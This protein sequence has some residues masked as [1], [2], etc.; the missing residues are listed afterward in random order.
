MIAYLSGKIYDIQ[1]S[2]VLVLDDVI[3]MAEVKPEQ[4][5]SE[6]DI[7]NHYGQPLRALNTFCETKVMIYR[8]FPVDIVD[9]IVR[10]VAFFENNEQ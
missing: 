4:S 9:E 2:R 8:N 7:I 5:Y 6:S 10:Q 1:N 3:E